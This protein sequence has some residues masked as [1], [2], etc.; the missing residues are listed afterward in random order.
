M[1]TLVVHAPGAQPSYFPLVKP[2]T[3]LSA[4]ADSAVI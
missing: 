2:L 1:A 3:T 4:G